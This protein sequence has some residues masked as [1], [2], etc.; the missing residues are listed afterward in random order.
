MK[1]ST[2]VI[3]LCLVIG[4][5]QSGLLLGFA[6]DLVPQAAVLIGL[7]L[8]LIIFGIVALLMARRLKDQ[9][10]LIR[11]PACSHPLANVVSEEAIRFCP[12]CGAKLESAKSPPSSH[13]RPS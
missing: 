1:Q 4:L 13:G 12:Q 8:L 10:A 9:L 3:T 5:L 6:F 11:C 7:P 2:K